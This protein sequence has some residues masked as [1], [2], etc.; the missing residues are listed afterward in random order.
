MRATTLL[1]G[2]VLAMAI[3]APREARSAGIT[4]HSGSAIVLSAAGAGTRSAGTLATLRDL[5]ALLGLTGMAGSSDVVQAVLEVPQFALGIARSSS[6][7]QLTVEPT[8]EKVG[9]SRHP[10]LALS[11][12]F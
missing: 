7:F 8:Y 10:G 5:R 6:P 1:A 4:R 12:R 11:G 3:A 2:A 9:R